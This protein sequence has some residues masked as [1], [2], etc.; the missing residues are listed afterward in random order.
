MSDLID[1]QDAIDAFQTVGSAF[2]YG[3]DVCKAIVSRLKK[4]PT[5]EPIIRCKDCKHYNAGYECL[6]EGYGIEHDEDWFCA[7]AERRT[8]DS[9]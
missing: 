1:R 6:I 5:A 7:D 8:D 9:Q 3:D 4:L 2:V